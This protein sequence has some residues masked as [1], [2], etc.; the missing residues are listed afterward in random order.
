VKFLKKQDNNCTEERQLN[1]ALSSEY[2]DTESKRYTDTES[3]KY[4]NR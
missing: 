2:T 3:K 4:T 1:D